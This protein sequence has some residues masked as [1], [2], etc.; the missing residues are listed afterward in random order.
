MT[1]SSLNMLASLMWLASFDHMPL[2]SMLLRE[3]VDTG[4]DAGGATMAVVSGGDGVAVVRSGEVVDRTPARFRWSDCSRSWA[5][6]ICPGVSSS[7]SYSG[8]SCCG[9]RFGAVCAD[10]PI[11]RPIAALTT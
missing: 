8:P 7:A 9:A 11:G 5:R 4:A 2:Q 6:R 3:P 10:K 1:L